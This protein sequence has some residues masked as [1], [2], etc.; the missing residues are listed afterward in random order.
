MVIIEGC[1]KLCS[2]KSIGYEWFVVFWFFG[3]WKLCFVIWRVLVF[4]VDWEG[5]LFLL[6]R[7]WG[8]VVFVCI[9]L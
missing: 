4:N 7:C 9:V 6:E 3:S 1:V 5:Y 8:I 2:E